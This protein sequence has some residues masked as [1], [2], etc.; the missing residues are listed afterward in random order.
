MR[1]GRLIPILLAALTAA[2]CMHTS[3][4]NGPTAQQA[5]VTDLDSLAYERRVTVPSTA[6]TQAQPQPRTE[7]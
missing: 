2:G 4:P 5:A 6:Y 7:P 3:A 1:P